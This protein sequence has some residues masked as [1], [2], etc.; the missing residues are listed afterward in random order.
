[1]NAAETFPLF[2]W[3][4]MPLDHRGKAVTCL[5]PGEELTTPSVLVS[6]LLSDL[7]GVCND[8]GGNAV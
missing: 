3:K 7:S 6:A 8:S 4:R 2:I 5:F 1:M